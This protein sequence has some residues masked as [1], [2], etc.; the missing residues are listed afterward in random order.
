MDW[1]AILWYVIL[2]SLA[3]VCLYLVQRAAV[4]DG[5]HDYDADKKREK[6]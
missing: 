3:L 5:M 2:V 4:R 1:S 6:Q